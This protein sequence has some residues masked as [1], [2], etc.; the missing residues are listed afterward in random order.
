MCLILRPDPPFLSVY[1]TD[2]A[3]FS[4]YHID[5]IPTGAYLSYGVDFGGF[6][7]SVSNWLYMQGASGTIGSMPFCR[8]HKSCCLSTM[9]DFINSTRPRRVFFR[10]VIVTEMSACLKRFTRDS[11]SKQLWN[12]SLTHSCTAGPAGLSISALQYWGHINL[13]KDHQ[14]TTNPV[15]WETWIIWNKTSYQAVMKSINV[16]NLQVRVN[17]QYFVV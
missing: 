15:E 11:H 8:G 3:L 16:V 2:S 4:I 14:I 9:A 6:S 5:L 7:Q 12:N 17:L 13:Q 10:L 1:Q